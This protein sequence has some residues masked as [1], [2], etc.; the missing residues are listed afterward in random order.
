MTRIRTFAI[1]LAAGLASSAGH[2][3]QIQ[4]KITLS[5]DV[6]AEATVHSVTY[7]C[8]DGISLPVS[9]INAD[10]N[11][12]AIVPVDGKSIVFASVISGSGARYAA[13]KYEWWSKGDDASLR[14]LTRDE[15]AEPILECKVSPS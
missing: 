3:Q 9:Y 6:P 14:D 7:G 13:G 10:P 12:L 15:N 2:A 4:P 5:I 8:G 11:F 1:A